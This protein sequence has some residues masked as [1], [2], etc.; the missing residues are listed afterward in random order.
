ME[1]YEF[2]VPGLV[3]GEMLPLALWS[4]EWKGSLVSHG[5][6]TRG[7]GG[8][9]PPG[10]PSSIKGASASGSRSFDRWQSKGSHGYLSISCIEN[11]AVLIEYSL[12][13]RI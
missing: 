4:I 5:F 2:V 13:V 11:I 10:G 12:I 7:R 9:P 1:G 3:N 8:R 6:Y